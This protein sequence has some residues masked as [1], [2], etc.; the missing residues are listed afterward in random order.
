MATDSHLILAS[1]LSDSASRLF[2][3]IEAVGG[4]LA[5]LLIIFFVAGRVTG[6]FERPLAIVI[7]LGPALVLVLI[8]LVIP[9]ITTFNT[10]LRN[11]QFLGQ[12]KTKYVGLRNYRFDFTDHATIATLF[13]TLL[14][15]I[16]VPAAA[17]FVGLLVALLVDRMKFSAVAKTL[18]F[19]P[20]AISFVGAAVIWSYVYNYNDPSQPQT[21]LLSQVVMK[22]GWHNPPNW[23]I[24]SPLN[25]YLEMVIMVWI[26]AGF[27]MVVLGAALRAIPDEI[28]EA[29][30]MD[31]ASG[32]K[33]FRTIQIPMIRNTLVVVITTVMITT[34][35]VFDIVA[36]LN[37]G[38]FNTDVLARQMYGDLFVTSQVSRGSSLAVLLFLFV[39]PLVVYNVTQLRKERSTR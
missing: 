3:V 34:L 26:Q 11:Q 16:I 29:A 27:A 35:K 12:K 24:S 5:I 2:S 19:L 32:V 25:V 30:R 37:N 6:R 39:L 23:L 8:G 14:W 17:V 15:L 9:A 10:S 31:G 22:L 18:I 1:T 21:G 36:T 38:A 7:C 4:F 20:T 33:L 28:L 13:R